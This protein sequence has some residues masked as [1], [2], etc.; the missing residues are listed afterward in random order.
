[1][2]YIFSDKGEKQMSTAA[3]ATKSK[4]VIYSEVVT[5]TPEIATAWL[6]RNGPNRKIYQ[7]RVEQY[8][9]AMVHG[10]WLLN[11]ESIIFDRTGQLMNGQHRLW[12]CIFAGVSFQTIVQ[13][14]IA[15][16]TRGKIDN[17]RARRTSAML[18]VLYP[19]LSEWAEILESAVNVLYPYALGLKKVSRPPDNNGRVQIAVTDEMLLTAAKKGKSF[20]RKAALVPQGAAAA[21]YYLGSFQFPTV[22]EQYLSKILDGLNLAKLDPAAMV[23]ELLI[24]RKSKLRKLGGTAGVFEMFQIVAHGLNLAIE[25]RKVQMLRIPELV[26]IKGASFDEVRRRLNVAPMEKLTPMD[27]TLARRWAN[28]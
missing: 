24:S 15:P 27:E 20:N 2:K 16:E 1:M 21:L 3:A 12:A 23:R 22:T 25:G 18:A 17:V 14:G 5:V 28:R 9:D 10:R 26:E 8:A 19:D 13:R 11:G 4:A 6:E 7:F